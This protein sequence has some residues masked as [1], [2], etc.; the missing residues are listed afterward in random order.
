MRMFD[1]A[2]KYSLFNRETKFDFYINFEITCVTVL[3][4]WKNK[5]NFRGFNFANVPFI[6]YEVNEKYIMLYLLLKLMFCM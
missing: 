2:V 1:F 5:R 6:C 4:L 3:N